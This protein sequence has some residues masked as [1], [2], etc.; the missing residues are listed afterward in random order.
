VTVDVLRVVVDGG[1]P[2][3][4]VAHVVA[5]RSWWH[6]EVVMAMNAQFFGNY[7]IVPRSHPND[8]GVDVLSVD[9]AMSP[10]QRWQARS[11]ARTG[12]HLPHPLLAASSAGDVLF[13]FRRPL[14]VWV[15]GQRIGRAG[16][17]HVLVEPDALT[18]YV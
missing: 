15:D 17:L 18:L 11:R 6:G 7:D 12:V 16:T 9:T 1:P 3:W 13:R 10:R 14:N 2:T 8:G 5:R 4:A